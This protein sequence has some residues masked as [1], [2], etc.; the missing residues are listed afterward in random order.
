[1]IINTPLSES[2]KL[3]IQII[4]TQ[5]TP[6]SIPQTTSSLVTN[7]TS[8]QPDTGSYDFTPLT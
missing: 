7:T 4:A 3:N 1:M 5:P 6:P 2:D 8:S